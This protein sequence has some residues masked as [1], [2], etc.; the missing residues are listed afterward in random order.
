MPRPFRFEPHLCTEYRHRR[1]TVMGLGRFGGGVGAVRFLASVG[2]EVTLTDLKPEQELAESLA[3]IA[4]VPLAALRL[5]EHREADFT[6]AELVVASPAV[7]PDHPCLAAARACGVPVTTEI[8]LFIRHCP[9]RIIGVTGTI[10]KSTTAAMIHHL[11][12]E[13]GRPC[14]LGGNIG[15]SLLSELPEIDPAEWVV[16]E[17]SSFQLSYL[18]ADR[19]APAIG[20]VTNFLPN[21]LDWHTSLEEY[22]TAKQALLRH[23]QP[24]D[25]A[26]LPAAQDAPEFRHWPVVGRRIEFGEQPES[27]EQVALTA[28]GLRVVISEAAARGARSTREGGLQNS[29]SPPLSADEFLEEALVGESPPR[30]P[31]DSGGEGVLVIAGSIPERIVWP[32]NLPVGLPLRLNAAGAVAAAMAAGVEASVCEPALARFRGLP[33]RLEEVGTFHGRRFINDSK[34]TTPEA[35]IT[36]LRSFDVPVLVLAGGA[37]KGVDLEPFARELAQRAKGIALMG[38]TGAILDH[39]IA[40]SGE[41]TL[42]RWIATDFRAAFEWAVSQSEAGDII[43]LSPGCASFGWF[44]DYAER[45]DQFRQAVMQYAS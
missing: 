17:L 36:A 31:V 3:A 39:Q 43:L 45:G 24:G 4:D 27:G 9:A 22:R 11:L 21:H 8:G 15:G 20:V 44:R 23:Q 1:V 42:P 40:M 16:L 6:S 7:R 26:V 25:V 29:P 10:G 14:R 35:A 30:M 13:A 2:G 19:Y 38:A 28:D 18:E 12:K 5:G 34:A 33:H 41:E 37:D 32:G